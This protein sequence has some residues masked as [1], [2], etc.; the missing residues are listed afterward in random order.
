[1]W[2]DVVAVNRKIPLPNRS[3]AIVSVMTLIMACGAMDR[4]KVRDQGHQ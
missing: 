2:I 1:M 3:T 4:V